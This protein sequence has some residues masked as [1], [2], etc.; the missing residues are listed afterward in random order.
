MT[1]KMS[2]YG[3]KTLL[4][5]HLDKNPKLEEAIQIA[6][7]NQFIDLPSVLSRY[8]SRMDY[9][10]LASAKTIHELEENLI[11]LIKNELN[12]VYNLLPEL[13]SKFFRTFLTIYE[14]DLIYTSIMS[15]KHFNEMK[16][17]F[18][19]PKDMNIYMYCTKEKTYECLLLTFLKQLKTDLKM[20]EHQ[21]TPRESYSRALGCVSLLAVS[22]YLKYISNLERLGFTTANSIESFTKQI[23][24]ATNIDGVVQHQL[25]NSAKYLYNII[26]SHPAKATI[27][28]AQYVYSKCRE[29]LALSPQVIDLL[30]LYLINRYYEVYVLK[31]VF[32]VSW[33]FK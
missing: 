7:E 12:Y 15:S 3:L 20:A 5:T 31:Y 13:Y 19:E 28:E 32:S 8:N 30:T 29:L 11:G 17:R 4:I 14:L 6:L 27:Y 10:K 9:L 24:S 22:K 2:R 33:V 25:E 18:L 16:P 1:Y 21:K 26:V 23:I